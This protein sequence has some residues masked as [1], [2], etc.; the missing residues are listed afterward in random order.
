MAST[1]T[2]WL[3]VTQ[4]EKGLGLVEAVVAVA[5]TGVTVVAFVAA[6]STGSI[7]V[8]ELDQE[9]VAQRL[10]RTQLEFIKGS[11]Y[12]TS[13]TSI[14]TPA[15]YTISID[16]D[17]IPG[18]DSDIQEITVTIFRDGN[19]ILRIEDYKVNR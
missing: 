10:T 17:S 11:A 7:A 5:V 19:E 14:S 9:V 4:N 15:G 1:I 16:V 18:T 3:K 6:L 2:Q 8:A 13:Y 12:D